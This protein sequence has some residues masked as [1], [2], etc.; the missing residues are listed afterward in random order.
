[1]ANYDTNLTIYCY[2]CDFSIV[3][4]LMSNVWLCQTSVY[5][6]CLVISNVWLCQMFGYVKFNVP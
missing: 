5:V 1:M 2:H 3:N 4:S 6:K